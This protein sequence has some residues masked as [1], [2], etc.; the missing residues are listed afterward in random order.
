MTWLIVS[1][2]VSLF[3]IVGISVRRLSQDE[4]NAAAHELNE[5]AAALGLLPQPK[6]RWSSAQ[7][8][9]GT[10]QGLEVTWT[11]TRKSVGREVR[12][13]VDGATPESSAELSYDDKY[14]DSSELVPATRRLL[15]RVGKA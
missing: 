15:D 13:R 9:R 14:N 5:A 12:I 7:V 3:A 4:R 10:V 8:F 11:L 1:L 6:N 2:G